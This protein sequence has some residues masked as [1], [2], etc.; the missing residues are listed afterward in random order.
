MATRSVDTVER[1]VHTA[2]EWLKDLAGELGVE[3]KEV[4]WRVM[5]A[6]LQV[7]RDRLT[8]DEAAQLAAQLPDLL[9]G[10][11]YEGFDP[12]HQPQK[13]RDAETF[14]AMFGE[15]AQLAD[16]QEA[17][18]AAAAVTRVLRRHIAEGEMD[19]A[20]SQLPKEIRD[21]LERS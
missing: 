9:R 15:R 2:N 4:A 20:M 12:G 7:L 18:R 10:V 13:I 17:A 14:L 16:A 5:R 8:V 1:N 6:Y 3:D 19:D 11:F 21:V